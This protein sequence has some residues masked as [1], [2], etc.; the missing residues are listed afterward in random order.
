MYVSYVQEKEN[1]N[2]IKNPSSCNKEKETTYVYI[3]Y[4]YGLTDPDRLE[5]QLFVELYRFFL[6]DNV[7]SFI[8]KL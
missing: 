2:T 1:L 7:F 6:S 8:D 4:I 3:Y 5:R